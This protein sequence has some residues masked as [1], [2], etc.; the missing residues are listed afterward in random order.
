METT[1][2]VTT[3][4]DPA[5]T[6]TCDFNEL[7]ESYHAVV[8]HTALRVTGNP[9]DA[10]DVLQTVFLR[11]L[12]R[13]GRMDHEPLREAFFRKA[14]TNAAIDV[15]RRRNAHGEL[16]M[17]DDAVHYAKE[18]A[19][20]LKIL[21]RRAISGLPPGDAELFVLRYVEGLSNG[22]LAEMF[23]QKKNNITVRLHRIRRTLRAEMEQ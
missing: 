23:C 15:L 2:I 18:S 19:P 20:M 17:D 14:A 21:L 1:D 22:E 8:F 10:E 3:L 6:P 4:K 7:F 16:Q 5:M 9:A 13:E 12:K 11:I